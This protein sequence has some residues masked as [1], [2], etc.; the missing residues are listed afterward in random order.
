MATSTIDGV[1]TE[2]S[3]DAKVRRA[4]ARLQEA[5]RTQHREHQ[6]ELAELKQELTRQHNSE[7]RSLREEARSQWHAEHMRRLDAH[8]KVAN[9]VL[10]VLLLASIVFLTVMTT[11]R[12]AG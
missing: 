7:M 4:E 1:M 9:V 5:L 12:V 10:Y 2:A 11:L 6:R 3:V 8:Q